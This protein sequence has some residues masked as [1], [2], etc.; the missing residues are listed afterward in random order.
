MPRVSNL[1]DLTLPAKERLRDASVDLPL[2]PRGNSLVLEVILIAP[3][4]RDEPRH[5]AARLVLLS[6]QDSIASFPFI[7]R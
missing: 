3:N 2:L 7:Y 1:D 5:S 4:V 6:I